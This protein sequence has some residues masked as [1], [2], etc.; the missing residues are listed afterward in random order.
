MPTSTPADLRRSERVSATIAISLVK[1]A[2]CFRS[3]LGATTT[4]ISLY[5]MR[6]RTMLTL[7]PGEWVGVVPK[8]EFP[9]AIPAH[10]V[11]VREEES[12]PWICAGIQFLTTLP[13]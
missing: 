11:W 6:V 5:G 8:G 12:S 10:V 1:G 4:D 7:V 13:M 2:E 3:D 9:H